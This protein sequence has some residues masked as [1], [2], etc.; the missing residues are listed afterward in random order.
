MPRGANA[1][2]SVRTGA[3]QGKRLVTM[4]PNPAAKSAK[5]QAVA[6]KQKAKQA[7]ASASDKADARAKAYKQK[8]KDK[9]AA[10]SKANA[11][12]AA[13]SK[14]DARAK[15]YKQSLKE[16]AAATSKPKGAAKAK[17][18][19]PTPT[20]KSKV[21]NVDRSPRMNAIRAAK[22]EMRTAPNPKTGKIRSQ[23]QVEKAFSRAR[24]LI[25]LD[26][27]TALKAGSKEPSA[28]VKKAIDKTPLSP[29]EK[30]PRAPKEAPAPKPSSGLKVSRDQM[31][32]GL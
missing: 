27:K 15:A 31:S 1:G 10:M 14:V 5:D 28:R 24:T 9:D 23:A 4:G 32:L 26:A 30:R 21:L 6:D 3:S 8:L 11:K 25:N 13:S 17:E 16:K 12:K 7:K 19:A 22:L 20:P 18:S 29:K 2:G